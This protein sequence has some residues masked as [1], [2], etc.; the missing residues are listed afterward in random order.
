MEMKGKFL[1]EAIWDAKEKRKNAQK[2][3]DNLMRLSDEL[4]KLYPWSE[5]C[6]S[7]KFIEDNCVHVITQ[8]SEHYVWVDKDY[9][10]TET[11]NYQL[12]KDDSDNYERHNDG[13]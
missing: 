3:L 10:I 11:D 6:V 2:L 5:G 1:G 4:D 9:D 13:K 12:I 8:T 7:R